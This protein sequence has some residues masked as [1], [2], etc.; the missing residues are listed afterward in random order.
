MRI[1]K[2]TLLSREN[3]HL[4]QRSTNSKTGDISVST[5]S[6][7]TCPSNCPY[8]N[9]GCYADQYPMRFHWDA[10]S[11]KER[12]VKWSEFKKQL[13]EIK[14]DSLRINQAGD[15]VLDDLGNISKVFLKGII[16][17]TKQLKNIWTYSHHNLDNKENIKRVKAATKKGFVINASCDDLSTVDKRIKQGLQTVSIISSEDSRIKKIK[18]KDGK[19]YFK[20]TE[21]IR[22][23]EGIKC[24]V[25]PAQKF[26]NV[27]CKNCLLCSKIRNYPLIFISH[28]AQAKKVN[29]VVG[30]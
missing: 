28:G 20:Q 17:N 14:G 7:E 4:S 29:Q 21:T 2:E 26:E 19:T 24:V 6:R 30:V 16:E 9:N 18:G 3:F 10:I 22:T 27:N 11:K 5:N 12:G 8:K 15:L 23:P 1:T 13:R 25:C